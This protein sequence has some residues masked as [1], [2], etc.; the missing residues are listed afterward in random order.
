MMTK[1]ALLAEIRSALEGGV[2]SQSEILGTFSEFKE[3]EG[4]SRIATILYY[5]GGLVVFLGIAFF[6]GQ[7]WGEM[8][9]AMRILVTLGFGLGFFVAATVLTLR[10]ASLGFADAF[11]LIGGL[12]IPSGVFVTLWELGYRDGSYGKVLIFLALALLWALAYV[13]QKR[14]T[15]ALFSVIFGSIAYILF[16]STYLNKLDF[17]PG[18]DPFAYF[19]IGLGLSYLTLGFGFSNKQLRPIS[20]ALYFFGTPLVLGSAMY[21]QGYAPDA[22]VFWELVYPVLLFGGLYAS[23]YLKSRSVLVFTSLFLIGYVVKIMFEYFEDT[24]SGPLLFIAA[25]LVIMGTGYLTI[26][27]NKRYFKTGK[28]V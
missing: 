20:G 17:F 13:Y 22:R 18:W 1:E 10:K 7:K 15:V 16:T 23:V 11:H 24:L 6:I 19:L 5:I 8:Q 21:L 27:L 2:I 28:V 26:Y 12:L 4:K 25:G 9:S 14:I 3:E